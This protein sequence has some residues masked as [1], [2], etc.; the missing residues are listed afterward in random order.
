MVGAGTMGH[1]I[2]LEFAL[3]GYQ[4]NLV[5]RNE[6][7]L[8]GALTAMRRDLGTLVAA[9]AADGAAFEETLGRV[10]C[11]V[12]LAEAVKEGDYVVEA[13][14]EDLALKQ[15]VF[16]DLGR[17]ASP[18]AILASNTSGL[19][20][21]AIADASGRPERTLITHYWNPPHLIPLVEVVP[22]EQTSEGVLQMVQEVLTGL[23]KRVVV[24]RK[25]VPGFIG[26]RLQFAML[27]EALSL[28][29]RGVAT[30]EDIDTVVRYSL[31]R[32]LGVLGPC[33]IADFGG[34]DV[35]YSIL[36]YLAPDLSRATEPPS[37]LAD[38]LR[39]G[40][41]GVKTGRGIH[42]WSAELIEA[43]REARD[44]ALLRWLAQDRGYDG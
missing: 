3:G 31:G 33:E 4:V 12:G 34:L 36:T 17:L 1:S 29:E 13:V 8:E 2:A 37:L 32:R 18:H 40:D 20:V 25:D 23:G 7:I 16:R 39:R 44:R 5:D 19:S 15:A 43:R 28:V 22:G 21:R 35:F 26:N 24:L 6:A 27:R 9:G 10:S 14:N 11:V 30:A 41:L 38:A 42:T